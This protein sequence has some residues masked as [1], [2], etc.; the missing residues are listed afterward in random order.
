MSQRRVLFVC[1][2]NSARSLMAEAVL[3]DIAPDRFEVASAGTSPEAPHPLALQCLEEAE[4]AT[5]ALHS[6][7]IDSV[8]NEHW[9]YIITLCDKAVREPLPLDSVGQTIAWDFPDPVPANRHATFALVL[10]DLRERIKLFVMVH[11]KEVRSSEHYPPA[12]VFKALGDEGRLAIMLLI[13]RHRELCVC[14]LVA[15]LD[16]SQPT[17]SRQLGQLRE[18]HLLVDERRGQWV[19]YRLHPALPDWLVTA[20]GQADAANPA[21]LDTEEERLSNMP[22]RPENCA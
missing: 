17:I 20:L 4:L 14:E 19:Y 15:A 22:N 7:S 6:K 16:A 13:A 10:K 3:R 2:S 5:S 21:L 12:P 8:K 11:Q 1:N 9:D 18:R